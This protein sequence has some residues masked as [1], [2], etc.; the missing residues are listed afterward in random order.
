MMKPGDLAGMFCDISSM[1]GPLS[2]IAPVV[3]SSAPTK[4]I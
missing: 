2:S 3:S 1:Q 4:S